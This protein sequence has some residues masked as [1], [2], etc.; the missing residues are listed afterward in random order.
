MFY[1]SAFCLANA[2]QVLKIHVGLDKVTLFGD[3]ELLSGPQKWYGGLLG[4]DGNLY[5]I[6]NCS[7][8]VLRVIPIKDEVELFGNLP[9][10]NWK[11]H[12]GMADSTGDVM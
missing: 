10:G 5:G 3:T 8:S 11:W 12:G 4:S 2:N 6:P 9:P 7:S 1:C